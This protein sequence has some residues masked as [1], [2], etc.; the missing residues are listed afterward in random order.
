MKPN[1]RDAMQNLID[2]VRNTLPFDM[3]VAQICEGVCRGCSKKLLNYLDGEL[4]GW[5]SRLDQGDMPGLG[6]VH[7]LGRTCEKVHKVIQLNGLD[8]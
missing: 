7:S 1:T 5:Q 3:P 2:E 6:E 4:I 8:E